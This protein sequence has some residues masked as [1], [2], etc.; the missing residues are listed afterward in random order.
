MTNCKN[1]SEN[2]LY[3]YIN[4][5]RLQGEKSLLPK[6][7]HL[8]LMKIS[9]SF[10]WIMQQRRPPPEKLSFLLR[11]HGDLKAPGLVKAFE[12]SSGLCF[13]LFRDDSNFLFKLA[14][15]TG[16]QCYVKSG[17][18]FEKI[19][20]GFKPDAIGGWLEKIGISM[21]LEF[22]PTV[23]E[24]FS[25]CS[26]INPQVPNLIRFVLFSTQSISTT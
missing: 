17:P 7:P 24:Y 26:T 1:A 23:Q 12:A 6:F 9:A 3:F 15:R 14:F 10:R 8:F 13:S 16:V 21:L 4:R 25:T 22:I 11:E 2:L 19:V 20:D 18:Y 5:P